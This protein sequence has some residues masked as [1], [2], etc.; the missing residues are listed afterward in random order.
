MAIFDV[1]GSFIQTAI[2]A[3]KFLLMRIGDEFVDVMCEVKLV[4]MAHVRY[5]N[6]K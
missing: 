5:E 1:P 4:Y 3:D 2:P 6:G